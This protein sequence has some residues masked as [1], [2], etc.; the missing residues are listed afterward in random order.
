V[1]AL[2]AEAVGTALLLWAIVGS[3]IVVTHD[4]PLVAQ[5]FP[6]AVVVG[7]ALAALIAA[8]APVSGAHFNPVVTLAA[9]IGGHLP[10]RHVPG[11]V[12]AQVAGAV[13]GAVLAN[14][15]AGLAAVTLSTQAREGA[16][17]VVSEVGA[18][19][20]LVAIVLLMVRAG[21]GVVAIAGAVGAWIAAAIVFTPS[22]SFANPAVTVG[23]MLSDTFTG[24]APASAPAFVAAQLVGGL[25]AV[26]L[27]RI[28]SAGASEASRSA[29][30]GSEPAL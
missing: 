14:L 10:R 7:L 8:L 25:L 22:A 23:R 29:A 28:L 20:G 2:V 17:I 15:S 6:H 4:G 1:A 27:V 9:A 24:I 19:L 26:G 21:R 16:G 11:Y 3:G 13:V 30:G 5:I 12:L 18:T